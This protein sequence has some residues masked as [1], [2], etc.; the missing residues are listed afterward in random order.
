MKKLIGFCPSCKYRLTAVALEEKN[1]GNSFHNNFAQMLFG[2]L[3]RDQTA[4]VAL[5]LKHKGSLSSLITEIPMTLPQ[6]EKQ[7]QQNES[8]V[9]HLCT[10]KNWLKKLLL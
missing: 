1:Q 2:Y 3:N 9:L 6:A 10:R 4:F 7:L 5:F 8:V